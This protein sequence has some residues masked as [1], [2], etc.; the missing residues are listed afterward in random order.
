MY[1]RPNQPA[2]EILN[3]FETEFANK[4][5]TTRG[6]RRSSPDLIEA[7]S[8]SNKFINWAKYDGLGDEESKV[9]P[10]TTEQFLSV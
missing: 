9:T 7:S 8:D 4:K 10:L 6:L 5:C 3:T 1:I 2:Q